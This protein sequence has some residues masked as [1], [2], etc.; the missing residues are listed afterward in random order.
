[1]EAVLVAKL[2][3]QGAWAEHLDE[4]TSGDQQLWLDQ[5]FQGDVFVAGL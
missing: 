5:H 4:L 2:S 3:Y 1:V